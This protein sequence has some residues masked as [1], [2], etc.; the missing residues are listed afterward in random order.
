MYQVYQSLKSM[1]REHSFSEQ[2]DEFPLLFG[3][4]DNDSV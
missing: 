3:R 2:E 4:P 1:S